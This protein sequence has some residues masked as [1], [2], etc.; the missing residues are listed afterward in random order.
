MAK[1]KPQHVNLST[2]PADIIATM[3]EEIQAVR[4]HKRKAY[5][6]TRKYEIW[7]Q[8][9]KEKAL[10]EKQNQLS[11][12]TEWISKVGNRWVMYSS[13]EYFPDSGHVLPCHAAFIYYETY[14]SCGAFF[15]TYDEGSRKVSGVVVFTSHFFQRLSE[16]ANVPFRSKAMI[17]EFISSNFMRTTTSKEKVGSDAYMRFRIGYGIG[18]VL[19][20]EPYAVEIRTFLTDEQLSPSQRKRMEAADMDAR[21]VA[22]LGALAGEVTIRTV[23]RMAY[24]FAALAK[25]WHGFDPTQYTDRE[26]LLWVAEALPPKFF[27]PFMESGRNERLDVDRFVDAT[28]DVIISVAKAHGYDGWTREKVQQG[29]VDIMERKQL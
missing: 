6:G 15:P 22:K 4:Y 2:P 3:A 7:K 9:L 18:A 26:L 5:G 27:D 16:R 20:V 23:K 12:L 11:E 25:E 14:A 28:C 10:A 29:I 1:Q 8:E 13:E 24:F 19:S 21:I 17:Q